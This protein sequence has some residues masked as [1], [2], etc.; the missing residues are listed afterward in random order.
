MMVRNKKFRWALGTVGTALVVTIIVNMLTSWLD[1]LPGMAAGALHSALDTSPYISGI[2]VLGILVLAL[3]QIPV[4]ALLLRQLHRAEIE[5][6]LDPLTG[7]PGR[8]ACNS[9][10][11]E[12]RE[13]AKRRNKPLSVVFLDIDNFKHWNEPESGG[14]DNGS[15][16]L[17]NFA[18][19]LRDRLR[20]E[21]EALRYGGDEFVMMVIGEKGG[22]RNAIS[23]IHGDFSQKHAFERLDG[24]QTG[25][26]FHAGISQVREDDD[27]SRAAQRA[28]R[29]CNLAKK[30]M[31]ENRFLTEDPPQHADGVHAEADTSS[32]E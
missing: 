26:F 24:E 5:K 10:F 21:E 7:I 14:H 19:G 1:T 32:G 3:V 16:L 11:E 4:I 8:R 27:F 29:R 18:Q 20:R 31:V 2:V 28:E 22:A 17:R 25:L 9:K 15:K 12:M 13:K 30:G 23:S 6:S